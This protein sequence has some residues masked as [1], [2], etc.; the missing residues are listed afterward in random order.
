VLVHRKAIVL[1][2]A[3]PPAQRE[4]HRLIPIAGAINLRD[5]G[6]YAAADGRTVKWGVLYR[7][8]ALHRLTRR[9]QAQLGAL[10][11]AT[12]IDL[13]ADFERAEHPD[14]LPAGHAFRVVTSAM[15]DAQD[16]QE[17]EARAR[18]ERG[19]TASLDTAELKRRSYRRFV[20]DNGP[21]LRRMVQ[22][23]AAAQGRPVL[24]HC[25]AGKDRTGFAAAII[26]RLLG[27]AQEVVWQDYLLSQQVFAASRRRYV[28]LMRLLR[29]ARAAGDLCKMLSVDVAYLQ[30]AFTTIDEEYGSFAGYARQGLGLGADDIARLR[31]V[32]LEG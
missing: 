18:I 4:A 3:M 30:A 28:L 8:G 9:G 5:M 24:F 7:S 22:E 32:L 15:V 2:K 19:Q 27:A 26:L 23:V 25:A 11:L 16:D 14:R 31:E 6:G 17:R 12:L 1:P 29:G 20:T 10:E 21:C 13:R